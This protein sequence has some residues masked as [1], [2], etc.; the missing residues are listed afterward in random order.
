MRTL[1]NEVLRYPTFS[2]RNF[3]T[4]GLWQNFEGNE[5]SVDPSRWTE[6]D[7]E[8]LGESP[9]WCFSKCLSKVATV[10]RPEFGGMMETRPRAW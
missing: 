10:L 9:T 6:N 7:R 1:C 3:E 5:G 2:S 8:K 4:S